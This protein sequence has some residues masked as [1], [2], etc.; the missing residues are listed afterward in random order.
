MF[1]KTFY[2]LCG[3]ID[4]KPLQVVTEV[5]IASGTITSWKNGTLPNAKSLILLAKYFNVT[6][7][8]L[9]FGENSTTA[10][11]NELSNLTEHERDL[12]EA[13]RRNVPMQDA[14]D[15]LLK[16]KKEEP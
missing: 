5:G 7:D 9:L 1:W 8:Y 2:V 12:I 14:V 11:V 16:I 13:Y 15:T 4:K 3:K 6:T 10:N